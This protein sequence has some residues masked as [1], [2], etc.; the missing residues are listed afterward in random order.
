MAPK[1]LAFDVDGREVSAM[2]GFLT[3][4]SVTMKSQHHLG[5]VV[6][7][8]HSDLSQHFS[9]EIG[10]VAAAHKESFHHVYEWGQVGNPKAALWVDVLRGRGANRTATFEWRASKTTVPVPDIPASPSGKQLQQVHVFVWKAPI[11]E[12]DMNVKIESMMGKKLA[13]PTGDPEN[14]LYFTYGP[15]SF[16]PASE[17]A[18]TGESRLRQ[19]GG[20]GGS[21]TAGKF[22]AFYVDFWSGPGAEQAWGPLVKMIEKNMGTPPMEKATARRPKSR[23]RTFSLTT[24][25]DNAKAYAEG[26]ARAKEWLGGLEQN[27]RRAAAQRRRFAQRV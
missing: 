5:A 13:F 26:A 19:H 23:T 21:S 12:Y 7:L 20:I 17:Q 18:H 11:M 25:S 16:N 1:A 14:P 2:T 22:T 4:M 24:A 6:D 27:Y 9:V 15:V 10:A 8:V 3:Q